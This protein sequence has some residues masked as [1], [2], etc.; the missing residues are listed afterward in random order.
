MAVLDAPCCWTETIGC[1]AQ[2]PRRAR[3]K[4]IRSSNIPVPAARQRPPITRVC[5]VL[6]EELLA[7]HYSNHMRLFIYDTGTQFGT[8]GKWLRA[9]GAENRRAL[10]EVTICIWWGM[11]LHPLVHDGGGTAFEKWMKK[12]WRIDLRAKSCQ[13]LKSII[14]DIVKFGLL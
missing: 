8:I 3:T 6:R 10:G 14:G 7:F 5:K 4:A 2:P 1:V 13:I 12:H 9:I 11:P